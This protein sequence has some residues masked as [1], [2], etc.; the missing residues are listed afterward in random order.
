MQF[1]MSSRKD[2]VLRLIA[3]KL[4]NVTKHPSLAGEAS[5][6]QLEQD[7]PYI[8]ETL[9]TSMKFPAI[10]LDMRGYWM[11]DSPNESIDAINPIMAQSIADKILLSL[12]LL[13]RF[14]A[15]YGQST[16]LRVGVRMYHVASLHHPTESMRPA[17]SSMFS[18]F[19]LWAKA[20]PHF[21]KEISLLLK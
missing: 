8:A 19:H 15:G 2:V 12:A 21:S 9:E 13:S 7:V 3:E 5:F 1:I 20:L 10:D 16:G 14:P 17:L 11:L 18:D 4:V 6:Y